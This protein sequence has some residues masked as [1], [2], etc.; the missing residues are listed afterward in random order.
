MKKIILI[1]ALLPLTVFASD[2]INRNS[3]P[4]V[5]NTC[6]NITD[7]AERKDCL[8]IAKKNEAQENFKNFKE[9]NHS[10]QQSDF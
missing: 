7:P 10:Q 3:N 6:E 5:N 1:A 2:G 9:N 4:L 8:I